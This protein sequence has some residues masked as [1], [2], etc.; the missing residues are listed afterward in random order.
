LVWNL[1]L[2]C[3]RLISVGDHSAMGYRIENW[4][5]IL[6]EE[7]HKDRKFVRGKCDCVYFALE[8]VKKI[9]NVDMTIIG[10][11]EYG[12]YKSRWGYKKLLMSHWDKYGKTKMC[13]PSVYGAINY[14]CSKYSFNEIPPQMAQR[15][16]LVMALDDVKEESLGIKTDNGACFI[17][18]S[19]YMDIPLSKLTH[20]WAIR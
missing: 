7:L 17:A 6:S 18:M 2:G 15:G 14:L 13:E 16:D 4:E 9:T 10:K 8:I 20:A 1:L 12:E 11:E 19:G 5:T 3:K